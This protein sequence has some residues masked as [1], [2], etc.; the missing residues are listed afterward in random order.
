VNSCDPYN[1]PFSPSQL[2]NFIENGSSIVKTRTK[3]S[4]LL[5]AGTAAAMLTT[6]AQADELSTLKAQLAA[7]QSQVN[8]IQSQPAQAAPSGLGSLTYDRGQ[9]GNTWGVKP[10]TE[11]TSGN[12]DTGFT[13]AVT[14]TA[15]LPAPVAEVTVYGYVAAHVAYDFDEAL[16][17]TNSFSASSIGSG[18]GDHISITANQSRFGIKSKIDTSVGQ[19]RT[20]IEG[21]FMG[22]FTGGSGGTL[23]HVRLRHAVGHWDMTPNWTF[24]A[25][26][27]W[28][29]AALL[30]IGAS[31][32]DFAGSLLTYSRRPQLRLTYADGP[33]S[34]AVA[35]ENPELETTTNMPNFAAFLQYDI[36]GGH[37]F[38][39]TGEVADWDG[40]A[41]AGDGFGRC[42]DAGNNNLFPGERVTED[43]CFA[44]QSADRWRDSSAV[45][46]ND[47]LGWAIQAGANFNL[48]DVATLTAGVGY[49]EGLLVDKFIF[50]EGFGIINT[51]GD[52]LEA[53]AFVVGLSF[54]L[55]ETA[56][57]NTQF[58][59]VEALDDQFGTDPKDRVYKVHANVLWQP[60]KQMRMGWEV[61][62]AQA[63]F[64]NSGDTEDGVRATFG[65]WFFF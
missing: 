44:F 54:G 51:N 47:E 10:A 55:L 48:A 16:G 2:S 65:T 62:W 37:Q 64:Q 19:I 21:D 24:T 9:G 34:W 5:L 59:Y 43:A 29:T 56:T 45:A 14:P 15:D 20:Q 35:I 22:N 12:D 61:I 36:A 46:G 8:Q 27:T 38:I 33:L 40:A 4:T 53:I 26:Q 30:P 39:V 32:V 13:I 17:L 18:G 25:G 50:E 7:L 23:G 28:M 60:V 11:I 41:Y 58:S 52:P 57:F 1:I 42:S 49:G 31:T 6:T 3:L 63:H